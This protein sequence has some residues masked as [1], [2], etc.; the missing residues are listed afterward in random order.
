MAAAVAAT[1]LVATTVDGDA[2]LTATAEMVVMGGGTKD[3]ILILMGLGAILT[4]QVS[5]S[6]SISGSK[7]IFYVQLQ[8]FEQ[9]RTENRS[10]KDSVFS[11]KELFTITSAR[12]KL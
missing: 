2:E 9:S 1:L 6:S 8:Q 4:M 7:Q 5:S 3:L 11:V 12:G 10:A